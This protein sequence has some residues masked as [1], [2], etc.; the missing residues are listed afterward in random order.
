MRLDPSFS[1]ATVFILIFVFLLLRFVWRNPENRA[2]FRKIYSKIKSITRSTKGRQLPMTDTVH[3]GISPPA[4]ADV[5]RYRYHH[6][7]N[8][9][10][11]F[12]LER[13]LT[14]GMFHESAKGSSELAAVE[15]WVK[16]E[17]IDKARERFERHWRDYVSDSD[18]DWL[19][20]VAKC[21]TVRLP[22]GYF[23]LGPQYCKHTPF[24]KVAPVYQKAWE[25]VKDLVQRCRERGIGVLIDLHAL[26]GGANAQD[27][28]GTDSGKAGLWS[29][30]TNLELATNCVCFVAK[31]ARSMGGVAGIQIVNEAEWD[32]KGMYEWYDHVL[33]QLS[34]IDSSMPL[35]FSD[36]WNLNR[37]LSWAQGKNSLRISRSCNPVVI[38]THLY[39]C[40]S[41]QDK[42]KAPQ[43]II[44]EV[45]SKLA[46][47]DSKDGS[48]VDRGAGQVIVGEYSC[49]LAEETWSKAHGTAKEQIVRG[50]GD[51]QSQRYQRRAGGCF[52]WTYRMDW[53]PGGE[54][55]FRQMNDRHA[56]TPP[57]SLTVSA[58]DVKSRISNAQEQKE[59]RKRQTVSSHCNY[60]DTN[61]PGH[62]EHWRFEQGW[63]LGFNDAMAFCGMRPQHGHDGGDKIGMLDLWC[64][65]RLRE[66]GQSSGL[67][68]E[69]E[70]GLRQGV[71]DL[72]ECVGV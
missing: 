71:R 62:Y 40:F 68:W 65:K 59:Q 52:F 58:S 32:A 35:Y 5:T 41:D 19:R 53:M 1:L 36:A 31:Q 64:L 72:Y 2:T 15:S 57:A 56:L 20:D 49:V 22:I 69:F 29:S 48:V 43:Q 63:D 3:P 23:T 17:G 16:Y 61:Y 51:A 55:G 12:V 45:H 33:S 39:W 25:A 28:S 30:H 24:K 50:L 44:Y 21:T 46:E 13:W 42:Q 14:G 8:L 26:P 37:A 6:G 60:W 38:D 18:L 47:L 70:H 9:G 66:S 27:H 34:R 11:V 67:A 10:S 7:T 4:L 54:W